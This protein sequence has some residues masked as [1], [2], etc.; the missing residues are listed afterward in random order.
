MFWLIH[1]VTAGLLSHTIGMMRKSNYSLIFIILGVTLITP[2]QVEI[3]SFNYAP[4]FFTFLFNV[5]FQ[6]EL[7][8][9]VLRP[10]LLSLPTSLLFLY[11]YFFVKKKFFQ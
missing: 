2:A 6:E 11:I 4:A 3:T 5:L 7:S 1:L 8:T 9:R 10:L